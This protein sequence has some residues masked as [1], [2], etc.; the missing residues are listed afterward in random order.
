MAYD[1]TSSPMANACVLVMLVFEMFSVLIS[2]TVV[3]ID[4]IHISNSCL[5]SSIIFEHEKES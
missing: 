1:D 2:S 3:S 4:I 5:G